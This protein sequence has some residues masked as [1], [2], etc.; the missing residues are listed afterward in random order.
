M[1]KASAALLL[2][3]SSCSSGPRLASGPPRGETVLEVSG[4][5]KGGPFRLGKD[6]LAALPRRKFEGTDPVTGRT[7]AWE[8]PELAQLAS[9][10][11][12]LTKGADTAVIR[13]G[14]R[15]AIPIPLTIVR[16]LRPVLADRVDG[17]LTSERMIAWPSAEQRGLVSDPRAA[18]W[19]ARD[20]VAIEIVNSFT[21]YG[22]ALAVPDGAPDGARPGADVFGARCIA[23][24][25][26][27]KAGGEVGPDLTRVAERLAPGAFFTLLAKHPGWSDGGGE[28]AGDQGGR[29]LWNFLQSVAA[30][31]AGTAEAP[32]APPPEKE[33][34]RDR[35]PGD[36]YG[37]GTQRR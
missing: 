3:L 27:R 14:E 5:V 8:G 33:R 30:V 36:D 23:C 37:P 22:R 28:A 24:H 31:E 17:V 10:R 21:T 34:D 26:V 13:T 12:E 9:A 7:G 18:L 35:D 1:T 15:H 29:Q 2:V 19:W 32:E 6:E 25:R 16:Q 20:V 4:A 11:V